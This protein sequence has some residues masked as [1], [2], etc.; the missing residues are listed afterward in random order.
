VQE[1]RVLEKD[2][3][4]GIRERAVMPVVFVPFTGE[5]ERRGERE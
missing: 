1:L 3:E 5:A 4:G 2:A